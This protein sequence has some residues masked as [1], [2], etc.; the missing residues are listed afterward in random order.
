M[1]QPVKSPAKFPLGTLVVVDPDPVLRQSISQAL[2]KA[3]YQVLA[4]AEACEEGWTLVR[5]L[6]PE[7]VVLGQTRA[8]D[9]LKTIRTIQE[10]DLGGVVL[11]GPIPD[12]ETVTAARAAG[13]DTLLGRPPREADLVAAVEICRAR[14]VDMRQV[15]KEMAALT[16]RL[17]TAAAV[18]RAKEV[19]MRREE[20]TETEAFRRL[21]RQAERTGRSLKVIAEAVL[22]AARVAPTV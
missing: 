2:A 17:E 1:S 14:R 3:G 21:Q 4:E 16:E 6:T 18:Q 13:V 22:L 12:V 11:L 9:A 20:I 10:A 8:G 5:K 7:V 19:L 15:R